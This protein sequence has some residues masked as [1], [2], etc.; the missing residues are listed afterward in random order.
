[1]VKQNVKRAFSKAP[2]V[3]FIWGPAQSVFPDFNPEAVLQMINEDPVARGALLHKVDKCMEGDYCVLT[4]E[5]LDY[6]RSFEL[7]LDTKYKFRTDILRKTFLYLSLFNNAY[8]EVVKNTDNTTKA[9][10][11]LDT[12]N[13]APRTEPNGD[14]ISYKLV[15]S[16]VQADP[17]W[18]KDMIVWVKLNDRNRG[19]APLDLQALWRIL[20]IKK[21]ILRYVG[22]AW[23]TG[24]YR[25]VHNLKDSSDKDIQ[26]FLAY[27]RKVDSDY[28]KPFLAKG[29][30]TTSMLRDMK[31]T[32]YVVQMLKW[33][34][35]QI[36]ILLRVPP[37]DVGIPDSSGRS[38]ADAQS[39]NFHTHVGA[40]RKIVED[41][42]N[43]DL[44]P[45][46][47][48]SNNLLRFGP[49]DRFAEKQVYEVAQIM[50]SIGMKTEVI[51]EYLA[52]KGIVFE[53][54]ELFEDPVEQA[55][56]MA[57][58]TNVASPDGSKNP[59]NKDMA[60]S[61]RGKGTGEGNKAQDEVT[62]REDQL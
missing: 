32:E 47:N 43:F 22:W 37:I 60:P 8:I 53:E 49:I 28:S 42:V 9:L 3:N 18:S 15:T 2:L 51:E 59:R 41:A 1:M 44:L 5:E 33:L 61:R 36:C 13:V 16:P 11:V 54:E 40:L 21:F 7:L 17:E 4:R 25:I 30:Y 26:D 14:P 46:I 34:D 31:E 45:K 10:N 58:A 29:E 20:H 48:K 19:I 56:Q 57:D 35:N 27:N 39:N 12:P 24:Q 6:D 55:A 50:K 52:D 23:E 62:T 38:N